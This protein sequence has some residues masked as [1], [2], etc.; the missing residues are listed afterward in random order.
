MRGRVLLVAILSF[1]A[2]SVSFSRSA[3]FLASP[4]FLR[5]ARVV[6]RIRL[7]A[8]LANDYESDYVLDDT[9]MAVDEDP[10][11]PEETE[12]LNTRI[13]KV[14]LPSIANLMIIP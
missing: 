4:Q 14:M 11:Q 5:T 7:T 10:G 12:Y 9:L 2:R 3:A 1:A 8:S 6:P 13:A